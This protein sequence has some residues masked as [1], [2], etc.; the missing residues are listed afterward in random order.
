M[1]KPLLARTFFLAFLTG[2]FGALATIAQNLGLH[3]WYQAQAEILMAFT[4]CLTVLSPIHPYHRPNK[5]RDK[6][7]S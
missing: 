3:D 1:R 2:L 6:A 4:T 5:L 7:C